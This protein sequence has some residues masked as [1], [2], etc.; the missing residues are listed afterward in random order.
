MQ[1]YCFEQKIGLPDA[2]GKENVD[3]QIR[4]LEKGDNRVELRVM[5]ADV[6][7]PVMRIGLRL[8]SSV[9]RLHFRR[10]TLPR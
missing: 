4:R 9:G 5:A 2:F 1:K 8:C 3:V 10:Y 6:D 7:E